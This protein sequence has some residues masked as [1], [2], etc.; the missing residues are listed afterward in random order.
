MIEYVAIDL[1]M[2]GLKVTQDRILEIGAVKIRDGRMCEEFLSFVNPHRCLSREIIKLTGI[3]DE[4]V[5][6]APEIEDVLEAFLSFCKDA[7]LIGHNL[8]FDYSFLKQ[9]IVNLGMTYERRGIDTLKLARALLPEEEKKDLASLCVRF[10]I[11]RDHCHRALDDARACA[12]I[13]LRLREQFGSE[14]EK[15]FL[16]K[17]LHYKVKKR[18]PITLA[19][20][21]D[22][23]HLFIYHKIVPNMDISYLSRSE[24]SKLIDR[25]HKEYGRIPKEENEE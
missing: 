17:P 5:A 24:A 3:T 2:T 18:T 4:M 16:P 14:N 23:N 12:E 21:R 25:I 9:N 1:E 8:M 6:D 7:V 10:E 20:K 15:I 13:F 19:Q 11:D 22:L